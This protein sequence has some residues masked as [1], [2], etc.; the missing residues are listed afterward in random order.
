VPN[1]FI[2]VVAI[3]SL[4]IVL[5]ALLSLGRTIGPFPAQRHIVTSG[6]YGY[7]RHPIYTG[8]FL[9]WTAFALRVYS[10]KSA[11]ILLVVITLIVIKSLVEEGFLR[12]D[13]EYEAY[14]RRV[15]YRYVPWL[16]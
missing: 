3:L 13:T 12:H 7:V 2:V 16:V 5:Y 14:M 6:A 10:P 4:A 1:V 9:A 15:K 11:A 8:L